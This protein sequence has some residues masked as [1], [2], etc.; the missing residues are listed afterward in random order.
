M[1]AGYRQLPITRLSIGS[2]PIYAELVNLAEQVFMR[3]AMSMAWDHSLSRLQVADLVC[4]FAR[5][6]FVLYIIGHF[7]VASIFRRPPRKRALRQTGHLFMRRARIF[8][9]WLAL[10]EPV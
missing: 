3:E 6:H 9:F 5:R 2:I 1:E 10:V 8:V 4:C 7:A